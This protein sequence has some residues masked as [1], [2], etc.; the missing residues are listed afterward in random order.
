MKYCVLSISILLLSQSCTEIS[1]NEFE[2]LDAIIANY[3]T[4]LSKIVGKKIPGAVI[5]FIKDGEIY[6]NNAFGYRNIKNKDFMTTDTVFQVASI[7][8]TISAMG[9]M[10]LVEDDR[11]ELDKPIVSYLT[12]WSIPDSKYNENEVTIRRLLSHSAGIS[13]GGYSGYPPKLGL[14]SIEQSLSGNRINKYWIYN[15]QKVKIINEPGIKWDYSEAGYLILQLITEEVTEKY[16]SDFMDNDIMRKMQMFHS[17]YSYDQNF[18]TYLAKSYNTFLLPVPN[19]LFTEKASA[20]L[21]TTA[22][23]LAQMII[24]IMKCYNGYPNNLIITK[25][26]LE[27]MLNKQININNNQAMGLGFFIT[28]IENNRTVYGHRGTNKGW[29]S[30]YEFSLETNDGIIILTN[31]NKG[32]SNVIEPMLKTWRKYIGNKNVDI[33]R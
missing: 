7:S 10:K 21:Y 19:Y 18:D 16:F 8:K 23:D 1:I 4:Q 22:A 9:V 5:I 26:T 27:I 28:G 12:R 15:N 30:C 31:G 17:S 3:D 33:I 24:E 32:Y 13:T 14:P 20:G 11:I 25:E 29:R 6:Y 2:S